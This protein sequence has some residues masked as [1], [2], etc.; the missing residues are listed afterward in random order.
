MKGELV[1]HK[2][3]GGLLGKR[4]KRWALRAL[5]LGR[6][7]NHGLSLTNTDLGN[8]GFSVHPGSSDLIPGCCTPLC[9]FQRWYGQS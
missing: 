9:P 3:S 7:G 6:H 2:V 5:L 1:S 4:A 8:F